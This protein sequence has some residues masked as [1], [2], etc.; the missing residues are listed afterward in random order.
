MQ[1][2]KRPDEAVELPDMYALMERMASDERY[3]SGY[4]AEVRATLNSLTKMYGTLVN[5]VSSASAS[6][7][8]FTPT[9]LDAQLSYAQ[10]SVASLVYM[11]SAASTRIETMV[12]DVVV[13]ANHTFLLLDMGDSLGGANNLK[14][15]RDKA[16]NARAQAF[17][18]VQMI[19]LVMRGVSTHFNDVE[20]VREAFHKKGTRVLDMAMALFPKEALAASDAKRKIK[21]EFP[22]E[23]ATSEAVT[24]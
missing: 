2:G 17:V 23:Q 12:R 1:Q 9:A 13:A 8:T 11:T 22:R 4:F 7:V 24:Q 16:A 18:D 19:A 3:K 5:E 10:L 20:Y 6:L 21:P 14:V 15:V